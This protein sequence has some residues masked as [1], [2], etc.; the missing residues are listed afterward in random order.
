MKR[1]IN[2]MLCVFFALSILFFD[3]TMVFAADNNNLD[4]DFDV[5]L[6]DVVDNSQSKYFPKIGN[7]GDQGACVCW[8]QVYYQFTYM[9]N[10][11]MGIETTSENTFSPTFNYNIANGGRGQGTWEVDVYGIMK[12]IGNVPLSTV[13]HNINDYNNWFPTEEIWQEA[14]KYRIKDYT[15]FKDIGLEDSQITGVDDSDLQNIKTLLAQGEVLTVTTYI[16]SWDV[17]RIKAHTDAPE[18]N[19]YLDE[20]VVRLCDGTSERHRLALVGYNDNIW[21]DINNNGNIDDGEMGALKIANSWGTDRH[22]QGFMWIAYDAL[23]KVSCVNDCPTV[24]SRPAVFHDFTQ[25]EII[26][27]DT[28]TDL[29]LRYTLNTSDR[30]QGKIYATATKGEE[31]YTFEVG[32]KRQHGMQSST[33]SYD[34][35]TNAN[36]GTMV[37]ALTNIVPNITPETLHEYTWSIKFSDT[38]ADNT[39]LTV[40]NCEIVDDSTGRICKPEKT[41]PFYIDG[42]QKTL[43][44]TIIPYEVVED[45]IV[46]DVNDDGVVNITDVTFVQKHIAK[47]NVESQIYDILGDCNKDGTINIKDATHIQMYIIGLDV[48]SIVGE[49]YLS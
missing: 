3:G 23:N 14:M 41:F 46:G 15:I 10:R 13:P 34:G 49:K 33:Y 27:Y 26:P 31:E 42:E 39:G 28:D 24:N 17:G 36:D 5:S 18:N 30:S 37:C 44:Y 45:G 11:S 16:S 21:T 4:V 12:E 1:Y 38:T 48:Q 7:Q 47:I 29:Y 35:T 9:M 43:D 20:Y 8:A 6:P 2:L 25:I 22:N 19:K 40:K 32:P